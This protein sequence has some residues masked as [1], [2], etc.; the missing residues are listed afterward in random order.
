MNQGQI[1]DLIQTIERLQIS[2]TRTQAQLN[3]VREDINNQAEAPQQPRR[4][5]QE[6]FNNLA[7]GDRVTILNGVRLSGSIRNT[8]GVEGTIIRF[9]HS[10]V[11]VRVPLPSR[12]GVERYQDV[13]RA[14]HNLELLNGNEQ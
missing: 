5:P 2:L 12:T 14:P 10:Y 4:E 7:I 6:A 8:R 3:Q 11:F 13:R 1:D 9:S